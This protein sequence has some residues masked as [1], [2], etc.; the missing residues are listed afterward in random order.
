MSLSGLKSLE[1]GFLPYCLRK[2]VSAEERGVV[3]R[4]PFLL[5]LLD[6]SCTQAI[7]NLVKMSPWAGRPHLSILSRECVWLRENGAEMENPRKIT[8]ESQF[9]QAVFW[10]ASR[11]NAFASVLHPRGLIPL[12]TL[13]WSTL[14]MP[15]DV[16]DVEPASTYVNSLCV[17][18]TGRLAMYW[19][20][21]PHVVRRTHTG[22]TNLLYLPLSKQHDLASCSRAPKRW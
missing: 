20:T 13:P 11:L 21:V 3:Q 5:T 2:T 12:S 18:L 16:R 22:T 9:R 14:T 8:N 10:G 19:C 4:P 7:Y 17:V 15:G 6:Y 1:N